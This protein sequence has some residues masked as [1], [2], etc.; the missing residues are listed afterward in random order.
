VA[1]DQAT[2]QLRWEGSREL[3]AE[4]VLVTHDG[5]LFRLR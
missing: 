5:A 3:P 2:Q 4:L 1:Y